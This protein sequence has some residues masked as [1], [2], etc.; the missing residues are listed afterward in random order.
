MEEQVEIRKVKDGKWYA[1]RVVSGKEKKALENL[2]FELKM[3]NLTQYVGQVLLPMEKEY[4]M[5]NGKKVSREKL[6]FPGY[7]LVEANLNGELSRLIKRTNLVVEFTGDTK[8]IPT[9][10]KQKEVDRIVGKIEE[11]AAKDNDIP[12]IVGETVKII[13]GA[14][15]T[16]NGEI[17]SI[18]EG[19]ST[20]KVNVTIF[21]RI[22]PVELSYL[23]V[24]KV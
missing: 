8:G 7:L 6:T 1:L 5:K 23:Q 18:D 15:T 9:P 12:F 3:N 21:G 13:D 11:V 19:K 24:D 2:E 20:L 14:F 4:K 22:T 10:L 17:V 16:F